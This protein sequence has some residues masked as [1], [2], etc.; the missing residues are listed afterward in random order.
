MSKLL[1]F[2]FVVLVFIP[3]QSQDRDVMIQKKNPFTQNYF[4]EIT[5]IKGNNVTTPF[6]LRQ[7]NTFMYC[8]SIKWLDV[9]QDKVTVE[10]DRVSDVFVNDKSSGLTVANNIA[11]LTSE[12]LYP[13]VLSFDAKGNITE[14]A[15]LTAIQERWEGVKAELHEDFYG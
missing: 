3:A 9:Q 12:V 6:E 1:S 5:A 11:V 7:D 4:I 13:L 14:V 15:N 10:I 8:V 2:I